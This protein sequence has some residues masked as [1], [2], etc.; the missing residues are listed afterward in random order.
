MQISQISGINDRQHGR[1]VGISNKELQNFARGS[2]S[3]FNWGVGENRKGSWDGNEKNKILKG[4]AI[5]TFQNKNMN[6]KC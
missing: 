6:E 3:N 4:E 2:T 5:P 1:S